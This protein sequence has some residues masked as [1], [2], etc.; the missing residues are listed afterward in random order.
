LFPTPR[1]EQTAR[2]ALA[3]SGH[4]RA[5]QVATAAFDPEHTSPA[6]PVWLPLTGQHERP[7]RLGEVGEVMPDPWRA[8]SSQP[9]QQPS[10]A[11]GQAGDLDDPDGLMIPYGP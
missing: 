4:A 8:A 3:A 10:A 1:R 6:G 9:R 11:G 2:R 5:L 7:M